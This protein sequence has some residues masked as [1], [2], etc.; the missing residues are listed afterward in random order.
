[1]KNIICPIS[2]ERIPEHLPRMTAF[3]V[4]SLLITYIVTAFLPIIVFLSIDFFLRSF[5]LSRFSLVHHFASYSSTLLK[6]KSSPIDKAPKLFAARL[7]G[8]MSLLII[9][10]HFT[11]AP[12]GA[13][14]LSVLLAGL[15]TLECV[16]GF[17]VGC[18]MYS[19]IV[20]P[21]FSRK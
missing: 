5:N 12:Y 17:C 9:V 11:G 21:V 10:L 1:M 13:I 4:I 18:Y 7:G 6:L 2:S 14:T 19:W 8:V 3:F 20:L 16:L 15:S